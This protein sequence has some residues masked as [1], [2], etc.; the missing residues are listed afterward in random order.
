MTTSSVALNDLVV[1]IRLPDRVAALLKPA[2]FSQA[3][4]ENLHHFS[5][6]LFYQV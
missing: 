4:R 1:T 6:L 5:D 3:H 2:H